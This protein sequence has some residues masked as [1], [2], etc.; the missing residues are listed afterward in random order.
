MSE[1]SDGERL[2]VGGGHLWYEALGSGTPVV[3]LHQGIA[4]H[5]VWN[6]EFPE[7][8]RTHQVVRY[9]LRGYG[10][11]S[12]ATAP[13]AHT[14][15][16]AAIIDH[17]DLERP[18]LVGPSMGGRIALD[19]ALDHP[20]GTRGVFLLAPGLSGMEIELDPEGKGAFDEDERRSNAI[21]AAWGAGRKD[22]AFEGLRQ[23][24]CAALTGTALELFRTMV[25]DNATEVFESRTDKFDHLT[26]PPAARRLG[27]LAT[28]TQ[29]LVGDRDN[30]SAPRFVKFIGANVP[31]AIVSL[32]AGADHLINLS[33]PAS[34]DREL[35]RFLKRVER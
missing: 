32:I 7:L 14:D 23:L 15:D 2:S 3:L 34:F 16:L 8:G 28:P 27:T 29:V 5:R 10:A 31:G 9:D 12:A 18:V 26:G 22:E 20:G 1:E 35:K 13:F 24:W 21:V 4:D 19:Y 33:Q 11:S 30:P 6:R 17:L 25:N